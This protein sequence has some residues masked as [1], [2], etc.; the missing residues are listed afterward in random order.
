M[1]RHQILAAAPD[2]DG[3]MCG[4]RNHPAELV[5]MLPAAEPWARLH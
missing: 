2:F 3:V 1:F 5:L 4:C